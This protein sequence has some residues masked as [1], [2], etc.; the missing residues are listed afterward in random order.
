MSDMLKTKPMKA[1]EL[2]YFKDVSGEK[3]IGKV[4]TL[5]DTELVITNPCN[6]STDGG[7]NYRVSRAFR[8]AMHNMI[9]VNR[10]NIIVEHRIPP[11]LEEVYLKFVEKD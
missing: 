7:G 4:T 3:F 11:A 6:Y 10:C 5:T 8:E 1:N 2:F 9:I